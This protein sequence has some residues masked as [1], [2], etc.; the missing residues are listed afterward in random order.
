VSTVEEAVVA[1]AVAGASLPPLL[2]TPL[3]FYA[4][5]FPQD[6]VYPALAY[7]RI[8]MPREHAMGT[9]PGIAHPRFQLTCA[10]KT[11][12]GARALAD[13][14]RHDFSR[15]RGTFA[16]VVVQ[17]VFVENAVDLPFDNEVEVHLVPVDVIVHH[18]ET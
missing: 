12:T 3:R 4:V 11:R 17:D 5:Q 8:S 6:V 16:G 2:G 15:K 10:D 18:V 9:D 1:I 13:A 7:Q 14:A